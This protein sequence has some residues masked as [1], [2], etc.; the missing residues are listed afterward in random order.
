MPGRNSKGDVSD[1]CEKLYD[2]SNLK[3]LF[4][5]APK[6]PRYQHYESE[7]I[8]EHNYLLPKVALFANQYQLSL[9]DAEDVYR[10]IL[11]LYAITSVDKWTPPELLIFLSV[12]KMK[13]HD[14]FEKLRNRELS[15]D[16]LVERIPWPQEL[17]KEHLRLAGHLAYCLA[18]EAQI[19]AGLQSD[20]NKQ[21]ASA[22][23]LERLGDRENIIPLICKKL[24]FE[25]S[26]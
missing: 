19:G 25:M 10:Q 6:E 7:W 3:M 20:I 9:R 14:T 13:F 17:D 24:D 8:R 23:E 5:M 2:Q 12:M 18:N 21:E 4:S 11:L 1:F 26:P 15:Y 22:A 16:K